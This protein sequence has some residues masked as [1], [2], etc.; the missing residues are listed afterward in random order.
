[1]KERILITA[2]GSMSSKCAIESLKK[3]GCF[4]V[5]CDIYSGQWHYETRLCDAFEQAAYATRPEEFIPFL[6]D[7]CKKYELDTILPLTDL[8]IDVLNE[9]RYKLHGMKLA[10]PDSKVLDIARNKYALYKYF[11]T[12]AEVPSLK[13]VLLKEVGGE[14]DVIDYPCVAKPYNGRS[15]EGLIRGA[16]KED[17]E[18]IAKKE[19][20]ILQE[21]K[22][23]SICTVDYVRSR[24]TGEDVLVAREELLRTKNGAGTTVRVFSD[25]VLST[26]VHHI[27]ERL[28]IGSAINMEFIHAE[29][30][31]YY[32]I[33]I[34]PRFSAGIAFTVKMGFDI[35]ANHFK[36][37]NGEKLDG[38]IQIEERYIVKHWK[39]DFLD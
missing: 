29:D 26:L 24:A 34:N 10:M 39:E 33:D 30:G 35:V 7:T 8:E 37:L 12:D 36:A 18:A 11:E 3:N 5:G 13:T 20:Y 4:V 14:Q 17:V 28:D 1:M 16:R 25:P 27:G 23:G 2:I 32:L 31:R 22:Q 9:N 38:Q 19:A 21:Q 6:L 15:S